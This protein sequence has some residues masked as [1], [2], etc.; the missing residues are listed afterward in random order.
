MMCDL[1]AYPARVPVFGPRWFSICQHGKSDNQKMMM[2]GTILKKWKFG[3]LMTKHNINHTKMN[4]KKK[5]F[6]SWCTFF[7]QSHSFRTNQMSVLTF[8]LT[9]LGNLSQSI[10]IYS[11]NFQLVLCLHCLPRS[12]RF[13]STTRCTCR[14]RS[15][16]GTTL[17]SRS[18]C[19][20][21]RLNQWRWQSRSCFFRT[22]GH[23]RMW[24]YRSAH[25]YLK[26]TP[27]FQKVK[28]N[29]TNSKLIEKYYEC[30]HAC[31]RNGKKFLKSKKRQLQIYNQWINIAIKKF[32][33]KYLILSVCR[34]I[35]PC[36]IY[37]FVAKMRDYP[38][39]WIKKG[40]MVVSVPR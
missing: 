27:I 14:S 11:S 12:F 33:P 6:K 32:F 2:V 9:E 18:K 5:N 30:L 20:Q 17:C 3:A 19:F 22:K 7:W 39:C 37:A 40:R 29:K 34:K 36:I 13:P 1:Q 38:T 35:C 10:K 24:S 25:L 31:S 15:R 26:S 16:R 21:L 28:T 4:Q 8:I 23:C